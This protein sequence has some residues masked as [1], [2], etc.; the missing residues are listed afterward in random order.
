MNWDDLRFA[1][2]VARNGGIAGAARS[3][4][5]NHSTVFRRIAGIEVRLGLRLFERLPGGYSPTTVGKSLLESAARVEEE[6]LAIE[7][8]IAGE[9]RHL[10]GTIRVTAT[11]AIASHLILPVIPAF[12]SK[13]PGI[14]LEVL[15]SNDKLDLTRRQA[16]VALRITDEPPGHLVGRKIGRLN[17]A[18]YR[19]RSSPCPAAGLGSASWVGWSES[20]SLM[21]STK[22]LRRYHPEI[23]PVIRV[24]SMPAMLAAVRSGVGLAILPVFLGDAMVNLIRVDDILA[25]LS[26]E[27]WLLSH[28][29]IR[30]SQPIQALT[31][32]LTE[33]LQLPVEDLAKF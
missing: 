8:R 10:C 20:H 26:E 16:D 4:K 17:Y 3:L 24:S 2:A 27:L 33:H 1:L 5:V 7:R 22:W 23:T 18:V 30:H 15:A 14:H 31:R 25:D 9:D 32:F 21:R 29:D 13:Y 12:R 11:D 19:A 28:P 6:I